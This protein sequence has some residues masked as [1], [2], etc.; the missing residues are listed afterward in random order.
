[1]QANV[2]D[3]GQALDVPQANMLGKPP[4]QKSATS[5]KARSAK[6]LV[7]ALLLLSAIPLAI[8]A[9]R[10]SQLAGG[11]AITP[12]NARFFASPLPVVLHI[13]SAGVYAVVGAFQFAPTFRRRRPGWH[14]AAG[15]LVVLCGLLVGLSG[16]WMT[17]FYPWPKGDGALLYTLRLVFSTAMADVDRP[18]LC[19]DSARGRDRAPRL[20]D[21]RLRDWAGCRHAGA[22]LGGRRNDRWPAERVQPSAAD[23][24]G[25]AHQPRRGRMGHPQATAPSSPQ[26]SSRHFPAAIK[27]SFGELTMTRKTAAIC[28]SASFTVNPNGEMYLGS[29][30][31]T[32]H[33]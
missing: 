24:R 6:W 21:A 31:D 12:A 26:D 19:H 8:G 30:P 14:R 2:Y 32:Y 16:L 33:S 17:L 22:D 10:L 15:R 18:W 9:F 29:N 11:A 3:E 28:F 1:M 23:G 25:L 4:S 20:D 5:I 13:M 27:S 7:A